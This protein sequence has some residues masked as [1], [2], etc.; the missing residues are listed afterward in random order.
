[1]TRRPMDDLP[2]NGAPKEMAARNGSAWN[3]VTLNQE[4]LE[5]AALYALSA[6]SAP[7]M[8]A[9]EREYERCAPFWREVRSLR[10]AAAG[11]AEVG[12]HVR[13]RRDLWPEI[14]AR[15]AATRPAPDEPRPV[16]PQV[17]REWRA[18]PVSLTTPSVVSAAE[19]EAFEATGFPGVRVRRLAV[20]EA[21]DR[22]TMLIRME[23]GTSYPAHR[24]A[25]AEE[26]FVLAGDLEI[27]TEIEMRAGDFQRMEHGS[28]HAAQSTR[29]GCLL[30]I[31]SSR[32]DELLG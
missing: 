27:G 10:D 20:D 6:L 11:L 4:A 9:L 8:E 1:M 18:T 25:G 31:T 15:L 17:W 24:H 28:R 26:C 14:R 22:V 3:G 19:D 32:N 30:L 7:E 12:A 29:A 23:P 5:Q 16:G 21:A 13:P 2:S